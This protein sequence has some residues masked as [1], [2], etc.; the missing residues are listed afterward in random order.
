MS[1]ILNGLDAPGDP[2]SQSTSTDENTTTAV[3][4]A[5]QPTIVFVHG[6]LDDG[7]VWG[8]VAAALPW[9]SVSVELGNVPAVSL[10]GFADHVTAVVDDD[11]TGDVVLVGQ[12][13]GTQVAELVSGRRP[14][15]ITGLVLIAPVPLQGVSL[16]SEMADMLRSCGGQPQVQRGIRAQLSVDLPEHKM[17][18]LLD[19]GLRLTP[20]QVAATY[21]AWSGG[22][23]V[24]SEPTRVPA[25]IRIVVADGDPVVSGPLLDDLVLPRFPGVPVAR[26]ASSGHWPHVEQPARVA[27][28]ISGFVATT[29]Q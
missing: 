19:S 21:D 18:R 9:P 27:E 22:H 16:P 4:D 2:M 13:M 25:P 7:H 6:F 12:S 11:V 1:G 23:P 26:I 10:D 28:V 29:V 8:E 15:R 3:V 17:L 5:G 14:E 20:S 24:G